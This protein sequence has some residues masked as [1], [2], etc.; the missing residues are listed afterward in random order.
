MHQVFRSTAVARAAASIS[1]G[2]AAAVGHTPLIRLG[3]LSKE[4]GCNILGKAEWMNPGIPQGAEF[5][6]L[7][8]G[9]VK[10]R[11]ALYVVKDAEERGLLHAGGT[12]VEGT[13]GNT[14]IGLAHICRSK[15]YNLV[16]FMPNTQS[17]EKMD[18]LRTLGADVRAVPAVPFTDPANYNHQAKAFAES[19]QNGVWTN[20]FDNTAN[21]QSHIETTGPE[22]WSQ[23]AGS[24]DAFVCATGT[25]G[26]LA[27]TARYLK[28]ISKGRVKIVL[29]DPPGSVLYSYKQTGNLARTGD[30]SITEG[31]GQ[32]RLTDNLAPDWDLIDDAVHI[33]D[34]ETIEM[35]FRLLHEEGIFVGASSALNVVAAV[36]VARQMKPGSTITTMICDGAARYQSRLFSR[37]WL[38]SKGLYNSIPVSLRKY[39]SL[40]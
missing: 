6:P 37:K 11:A 18:L 33:P 29:A 34:E 17:Q 32:G 21:R 20:Q 1:N 28:D 13:A 12:V 5:N 25:G 23:T 15:G 27:G 19:L 30:S 31:I 24:V 7:S 38:E 14:G 4:T 8:G 35:V 26:T 9:S 10:D 36:H 2:L 40:A 3:R 39:V 16:I 22:I